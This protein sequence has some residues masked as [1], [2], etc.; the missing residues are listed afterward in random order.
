MGG[1]VFL[2]VF[3]EGGCGV[4]GFAIWLGLLLVIFVFVGMAGAI[5]WPVGCCSN[6][7]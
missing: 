7:V 4:V 3:C 1:E 5:V 6:D 2:S